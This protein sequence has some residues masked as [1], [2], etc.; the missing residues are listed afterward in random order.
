M[1]GY[2]GCPGSKNRTVTGR[3]GSVGVGTNDLPRRGPVDEHNIFHADRGDFFSLAFE[4]DVDRPTGLLEVERRGEE[5]LL[6]VQLVLGRRAVD[7]AGPAAGDEAQQ[8]ED[9]GDSGERAHGVFLQCT[10]TFGR[11]CPLLTPDQQV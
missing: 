8:D 3:D 1:A 11:Y 6:R 4:P 5:F 7:R 9:G 2:I 10:L